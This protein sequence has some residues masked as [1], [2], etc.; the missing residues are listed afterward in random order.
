MS[1]IALA[2]CDV[3]VHSIWEILGV[4]EQGRIDIYEG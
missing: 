1:A 3:G 2:P 4:I